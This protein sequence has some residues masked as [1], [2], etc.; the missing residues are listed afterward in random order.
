MLPQVGR[1]ALIYRCKGFSGKGD[2]LQNQPP[3]LNGRQTPHKEHVMKASSVL[4][5][6]G[7]TGERY[8]PVEG[9]LP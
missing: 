6:I 4:A 9:G 2:N 7:S 3:M 8:L 1:Q 5:T